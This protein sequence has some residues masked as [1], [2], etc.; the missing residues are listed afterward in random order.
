MKTET[1]LARYKA[2][3]ERLQTLLMCERIVS[4]TLNVQTVGNA[5]RYTLTDKVNGKTRC[6]YV[7]VS[8][9]A[10]VRKYVE[11]WKELKVLM[12]E[13]S[14]MTRQL[15]AA[16]IAETTGRKPRKNARTG[17]MV[18][19]QK[20]RRFCKMRPPE[21]SLTSVVLGTG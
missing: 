13:M 15:L 7:P 3:V 4:G 21:R 2:T 19:K 10:K 9:E 20:H 14:E 18:D 12:Q 16:E 8:M 6:L 5:K 1:D 17:E 11:N